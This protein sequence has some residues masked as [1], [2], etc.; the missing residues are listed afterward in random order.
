MNAFAPLVHLAMFIFSQ[1]FNHSYND[2]GGKIKENL[3]I[4]AFFIV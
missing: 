3:D 4:S 1:F 2:I